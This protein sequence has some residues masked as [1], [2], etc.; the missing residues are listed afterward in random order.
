MNLKGYEVDQD[1]MLATSTNTDLLEKMGDDDRHNS[2]S[3]KVNLDKA[4]EGQNK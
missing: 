1:E 2:S 3:D 4:V